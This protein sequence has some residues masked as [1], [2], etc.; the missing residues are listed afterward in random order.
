MDRLLITLLTIL[1][2]DF[3]AQTNENNWIFG[4]DAE[5]PKGSL[6]IKCLNEKTKEN[7]DKVSLKVMFKDSIVTSCTTN[8]KGEGFFNLMPGTYKIYAI[9]SSYKEY[10][11]LDLHVNP[12]HIDSLMIYLHKQ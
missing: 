5:P 1:C 11:Q 6:Y 7:L 3:K 9:K 8:A 4:E 10:L 2:L 12:L